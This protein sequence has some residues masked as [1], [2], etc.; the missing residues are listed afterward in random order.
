MLFLFAGKDG[1]FDYISVTPPY[2]QVDYAVLMRQISDSALI[3]DDTFI[4]SI[5]FNSFSVKMLLFFFSL[6]W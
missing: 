1:P 2:E 6:F 5:V 3:G 4:V